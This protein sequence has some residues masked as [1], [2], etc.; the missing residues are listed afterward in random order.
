MKLTIAAPA[1]AA[2]A[3][4]TLVTAP[5]A[6]AGPEENFLQVLTENGIKWPPGKDQAVIDTGKAVCQDWAGGASFNQEVSDIQGATDWSDYQIGVFI[7]ASTAAFCPQYK[8]K[9]PT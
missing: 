9:L 8:S 7:G 4:I 5:I 3:A 1:V 6:S 2:L